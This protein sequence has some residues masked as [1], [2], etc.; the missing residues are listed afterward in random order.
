M[1]SRFLLFLFASTSVVDPGF[2]RRGGT[3]PKRGGTKLY[4]GH[5]PPQNCMKLKKKLARLQRPPWIRRRRL[6]D[7]STVKPQLRTQC[8]RRQ[9]SKQARGMKIMRQIER[10]M[11]SWKPPVG[12]NT[13]ANYSCT[14]PVTIHILHITERLSLLFVV[15]KLFFLT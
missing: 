14:E 10:V 6:P 4:V 8:P 15:V 2:S 1:F 3:N 5:F 7:R 11:S 9:Q 13:S 12:V